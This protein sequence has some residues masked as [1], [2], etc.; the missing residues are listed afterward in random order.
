M[1]SDQTKFIL[2]ASRL[3]YRVL[4]L[5]ASCQSVFLHAIGKAI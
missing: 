2:R 4:L 1:L 3:G 5:E